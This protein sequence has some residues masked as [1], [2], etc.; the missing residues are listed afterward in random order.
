MTFAQETVEKNSG[1]S[2][3]NRLNSV[4][5]KEEFSR[6]LLAVRYPDVFSEDKTN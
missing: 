1:F 5:S 6:K 2:C 3:L 4:Q